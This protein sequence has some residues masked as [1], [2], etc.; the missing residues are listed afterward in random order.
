MLIPI[1]WD[2]Y[3]HKIQEA[4]LIYPF[5][6]AFNKFMMIKR[7]DKF[8]FYIY[9][10]GMGLNRMEDGMLKFFDHLVDAHELERNKKYYTPDHSPS[11]YQRSEDLLDNFWRYSNDSMANLMF[12]T[13]LR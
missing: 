11:F 4:P 13:L 2:Y 8:P 1:D 12:D 3:W 10:Y 5:L 9:P 7:Y 6:C